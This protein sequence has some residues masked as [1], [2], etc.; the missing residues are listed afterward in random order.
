MNLELVTIGVIVGNVLISLKGFDDYA[1]RS[2]YM[3]NVGAIHRGEYLRMITS[4][5]L[6]ADIQHLAFNMIT[7]YFFAG[8][9]VHSLGATNFLLIYLAS[10]LLGSLLSFYF[11][12]DEHHY[13]ALGASGA[14]SGILFSAILLRPNM[15]INIVIP[16]YLFAVGY[17]L[18]SIYGMKKRSGNIGHDAHF[19][20]AVAG[21]VITLALRKEI[22]YQDTWIVI[23]MAVPIIILFVM[24]KLGKI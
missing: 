24:N 2:T 13:N 19:G 6:H 15:M 4:G 5:F 3:F 23:A 21:F 14:V 16:G 10:L 11:H 12:K 1:F 9:V 18:F 7:L 20:G 17:L 8:G 22:L